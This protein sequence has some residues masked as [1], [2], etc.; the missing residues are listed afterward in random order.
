MKKFLL[1]FILFLIFAIALTPA[2]VVQWFMPKNSPVVLQGIEGSI[3]S[4]K[5]SQ[6]NY[7]NMRFED[8]KLNPSLLALFTGQLDLGFDIAKGDLSGDGNVKL[9]QNFRKDLILKNANIKTSLAYISQVVN[10]RGL[11]PNGNIKTSALSLELKDRKLAYA[12]GKVSLFDFTVNLLGQSWPLGDFIVKLTTDEDAKIIS[13]KLQKSNNKLD[14]QGNFTLN[15]KGL[16][17][18]SG[19]ISTDADQ[20][21]YSAVSLFAD[22]KAEEGRLPI[23]YKQKLF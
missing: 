17:E 7:Q 18:F 14:L 22:G 21:I 11:Q 12:K 23:K 5:M 10:L 8:V 1:L 6:V 19:S 4:P 13:G 15:P 2:K 3:W 16:F 9:S 20:K